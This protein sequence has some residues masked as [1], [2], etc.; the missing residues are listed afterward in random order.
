MRVG[1]DGRE[2]KGG[3]R[4]GIGRYLI[5]IIR[6]ASQAGWECLV[7]GDRTTSLGRTW[8]GVT[9]RRL[10]HRWTQWWDQ[11]SLPRRL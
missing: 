8:P 9:L 7:Y 2:L 6:A 10:D 3:L 11:V 1:I 4:T 5:E